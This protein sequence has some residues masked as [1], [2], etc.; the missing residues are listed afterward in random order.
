MR[1]RLISAGCIAILVAI[2]LMFLWLTAESTDPTTD[3]AI[4]HRV[5]TQGYVEDS[6]S[7]DPLAEATLSFHQQRHGRHELV[8][9]SSNSDGWFDAIRLAGF[10][11]EATADLQCCFLPMRSSRWTVQHAHSDQITDDLPNGLKGFPPAKAE[12]IRDWTTGTLSIQAPTCGEI[13]INVRD[14]NG[15]PLDN[16]AVHVFPAG[17]PFSGTD[18]LRLTGETNTDGDLRVRWWVG[19]HR[20][21]VVAPGT[22]FASTG[23]F[24]VLPGQTEH[25]PLPPLARFGRIEGRVAGEHMEDMDPLVLGNAAW[26][27]TSTRVRRDGSFTLLDVVPGTD[28]LN[29]T[30]G[31]GSHSVTVNVTLGETLTGVQFPRPEEQDSGNVQAI[32]TPQP[33]TRRTASIAGVVRDAD[34]SPLPGVQVVILN[35]PRNFSRH[36]N[37]QHTATTARDGSYRFEGLRV[38]SWRGDSRTL[39]VAQPGH[40]PSVVSVLRGDIE[41]TERT[42]VTP[43]GTSDS[44]QSDSPQAGPREEI[45]EVQH[46]RA[47]VTVPG[48]GGTL[49]IQVTQSR[50]A[51]HGVA[52]RLT[53]VNSPLSALPPWR[54][55]VLPENEKHVSWLSRPVH[56]TDRNGLVRFE[57]LLPGRYRV[58]TSANVTDEQLEGIA[59]N[60]WRGRRVS[61]GVEWS[62]HHG[63]GVAAGETR[64]LRVQLYPSLKPLP[65]QVHNPVADRL[66]TG[67]RHALSAHLTPV[68]G[69][70][71]NVPAENLQLAPGHPGL[72]HLTVRSR[73]SGVAIPDHRYGPF[74]ESRARVAVSRLLGERTV[75]LTAQFHDSDQQT[76]TVRLLDQHDMPVSGTV[77]VGLQHYA[78]CV[79]AASTIDGVANFTG[80][81]SS[82]YSVRG[83]VQ[84]RDSPPIPGR[85]LRDDPLDGHVLMTPTVITTDRSGPQE[86]ALRERPVGYIRCLVRFPEGADASEYSYQATSSDE[87]RYHR[88]HFDAESSSLLC[89]PFL[90]SAVKLVVH[91][92]FPNGGRGKVH[93]KEF[94]IEQGR[95]VRCELNVPPENLQSIPE[96]PTEISSVNLIPILYAYSKEKPP[97]ETLTGQVLHA[98]GSPAWAAQLMRYI[99]Q[100]RQLARVGRTDIHGHFR[101]D[102]SRVAWLIQVPSQSPPDDADRSPVHPVLVAHIPGSCGGTFVPVSDGQASGFQIKLP[103]VWSLRGRITVDGQGPEQFGD[104]VRVLAR[105]RG[106]GKLTDIFSIDRT[107]SADGTFLLAGLTPGAYDVQATLDGIWLSESVRLDVPATASK[108]EFLADIVLPIAM[109]G[110]TAHVQITD[111]DGSPLPGQSIRVNFPPGPLTEEVHRE[112]LKT[113]RLGIV[114]IDG[115]TVGRQTLSVDGYSDVLHF[116]V[117][118]HDQPDDTP[119][120]VSV[121]FPVDNETVLPAP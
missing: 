22:G 90:A 25:V 33:V 94:S 103:P 74:F 71:R 105:Y 7:G 64:R 55:T 110:T 111:A 99:P 11:P 79:Y 112:P 92:R 40:A 73:R 115:C 52:V 24:E 57:H 84:D 72:W 82:Q 96:P 47:D 14:P 66:M 56:R 77:T 42:S 97:G 38:G 36:Y 109:P 100:H 28:Q 76:L 81:P 32:A 60:S 54:M 37:Y 108:R 61:D 30:V 87:D 68:D 70:G 35:E 12:I 102:D 20:L 45:H 75:R 48:T 88:R 5:L 43:D 41:R 119:Q 23:F 27:R 62:G 6:S 19:L 118:P 4:A 91:R 83:Y 21:I 98:D 93:E 86:V 116:E 65:V 69:G 10:T 44:D 114:R 1:I 104:S 117:P 120:V 63:I 113:D 107:A 18:T 26:N 80:I 106:H 78:T 3:D 58:E 16:G 34:G 121:Q 101:L 95:L 85:D 8:S 51:T 9:L 2:V 46:Y 15:A 89:G 17:P 53:S 29:G 59:Q 13:V 50:Q 39:I 49:E 31:K 67:G